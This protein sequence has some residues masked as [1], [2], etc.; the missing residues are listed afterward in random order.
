MSIA[1]TSEAALS[2]DAAGVPNGVAATPATPASLFEAHVKVAQAGIKSGQTP[3][4]IKAGLLAAG[5]DPLTAET[6]YRTARRR[7][8]DSNRQFGA[9]LATMAIAAL[10]GGTLL[11]VPLGWTIP[12]VVVLLGG[13]LLMGVATL[14]WLTGLGTDEP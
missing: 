8:F 5:V 3:S 14:V 11:F 10:C 2:P 7:L 1:P 6:A 9:K 12:L 4:Q 13:L